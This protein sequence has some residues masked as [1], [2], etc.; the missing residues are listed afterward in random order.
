MIFIAL[1]KMYHFT[2]EHKCFSPGAQ[3]IENTYWKYQS[4]WAH[5]RIGKAVFIFTKKTI[6]LPCKNQN[7]SLQNLK[8]ETESSS[9]KDLSF[10]YHFKIQILTKPLLI[11]FKILFI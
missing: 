10:S 3:K 2:W 6:Y 11:E 1:S 7:Y 8:R 5:F 4:Q 9:Q